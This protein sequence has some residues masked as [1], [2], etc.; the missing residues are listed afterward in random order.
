[1][2]SPPVTYLMKGG[3]LTRSISSWRY[4]Q[5]LKRL[6]HCAQHTR[7]LSLSSTLSHLERDLSLFPGFNTKCDVSSC[8][9]SSER[10]KCSSSVPA[11]PRFVVSGVSPAS[12]LLQ[13]QSCPVYFCTASFLYLISGLALQT[14][15]QVDMEDSIQPDPQ[16]SPQEE[17][18]RKAEQP[19]AQAPPQ[20]SAPASPSSLDQEETKVQ[21]KGICGSQSQSKLLWKPIPPLLPEAHARSKDQSC[22]TEEQCSTS[23]RG[24]HATGGETRFTLADAAFFPPDTDDIPVVQ[25]YIL[26]V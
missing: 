7:S 5:M 16:G 11:L 13:R 21:E 12:G 8:R 15:P 22:Q 9:P 26:L 1:M 6:D 3:C 25:E 18:S 4:L 14:A 23:S 19:P 2:C 24:H 17:A 20:T 10:P